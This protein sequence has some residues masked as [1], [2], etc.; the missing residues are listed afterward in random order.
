VEE[1]EQVY[2]ADIFEI[3][4]KSCY[5]FEK[6]RE[7]DSIQV[8]PCMGKAAGMATTERKD[9]MFKVVRLCKSREGHACLLPVR[10]R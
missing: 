8:I 2:R 10:S 4:R 9:I 7:A 6:K 5:P 3:L 1:E